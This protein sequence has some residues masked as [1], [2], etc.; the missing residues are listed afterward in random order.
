MKKI[1]TIRIGS[2]GS[3]LALLQT[4]EIIKKLK[5][6]FDSLECATRI[7]QTTGDAITDKPLSQVGGKGLF[8]KEIE[9]ALVRGDIDLIVHSMKDVPTSLP[10]GLEIAA[11]TKRIDC[12]D[13]LI[14]NE[15]KKLTELPE[16][17]VIGTGSLRRKAQ[18]LRVRKDLTVIDLRGNLDTRLTKLSHNGLDAI[19][20]AA[21]GL[22][23]LGLQDRITEIFSYDVCLPAVGQGSLGV[24]IRSNDTEMKRLAAV[25][26]DYE[27][28]LSIRAERA[29]L[30]KLQGGC[31]IPV[32]A[33][34]HLEQGQLRLQGLVA[35]L[36]GQDV[37]HD[38][39]RGSQDNPEE[40]GV[41]LAELLLKRGADEILK[42][43][44]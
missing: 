43:I 34:G 41:T 38:A 22:M 11:I 40:L 12:R 44:R 16:N 39:V 20:V 18:L 23:R 6:Q 29:F 8:V 4:E 35:S 24:E 3:K 42:S 14:S 31:R 17:A 25:L 26:N 32:G 5:R 1:R 15:N 30:K 9:E 37:L 33:R 28:N 36:D 21:A 10:E 7:I 27:S 19:V 2:R 13:A